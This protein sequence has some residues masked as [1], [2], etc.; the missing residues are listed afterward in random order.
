MAW[1]NCAVTRRRTDRSSTRGATSTSSTTWWIQTRLKGHVSI[2]WCGKIVQ[3][4]GPLSE[5]LR[6]SFSPADVCRH[7]N[8]PQCILLF[9]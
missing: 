8:T 5:L 4:T 6:G 2:P 1:S 3:A 9:L 7:V